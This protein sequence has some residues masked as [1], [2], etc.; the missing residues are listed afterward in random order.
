MQPRHHG[1]D[2]DVEDLG[3][4][5]VAELADVDEHD[6]VAEVV[7][8]LG[9]RVDD[10]ALRE[11]L[12]HLVLLERLLAL[13]GRDLVG[14][15]VVAFLERLEIGRALDLAAPVEVQVGE[16]PQQPG[17][18]VRAGRVGAPAPER[19]RIR[20]LHQLF[21]LLSRP[22]QASRHAIDLVSELER[23]LLEAHPIAR[24]ARDPAGICFGFGSASA[25]LT[26]P[27]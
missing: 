10:A 3:R 24:L 4:L 7:R 9:E 11:P 6:D 19:P 25:S 16:D 27:P 20:L 22:D 8:D 1:T 5:R 2:R 18:Q 23:L 15:V 26:G 21:R 17:A 14:E 13:G 12:D